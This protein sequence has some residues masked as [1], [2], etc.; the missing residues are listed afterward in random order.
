MSFHRYSLCIFV[1]DAD[2]AVTLL[3]QCF[4]FFISPPL[5]EGPLVVVVDHIN[6]R[7]AFWR[8]RDGNVWKHIGSY[9]TAPGQF[10][11][12]GAIA[13]TS[14]GALVVTDVHRVQVLTV[15]G[16]VL[17]VLYPTAVTNVGQ[18]GESLF[19]VAVCP[20]TDEILVTD[21]NE[22]RVVAMTWNPS[23]EVR[24]DLFTCL[25]IPSS[26]VLLFDYSLLIYFLKSPSWRM[27]FFII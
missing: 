18:L 24:L 6:N 10:T 13:L 5:Q 2:V 16:A 14:S 12:P 23:S 15:E 9:G 17:C 8:L 3:Y 19:G 20:R 7:L 22:H 11:Y 25:F 27:L 21:F 1:D 4:F 26:L